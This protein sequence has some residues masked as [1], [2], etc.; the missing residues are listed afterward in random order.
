MRNQHLVI[1]SLTNENKM[2]QEE[3]ER[4]RFII[5]NF[6]VNYKGLNDDMKNGR[7]DGKAKEMVEF[8][9]IINVKEFTVK[10]IDIFV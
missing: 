3:N 1:N 2:L 6:L 8:E 9:E 7:V 5:E 10:I 4:F